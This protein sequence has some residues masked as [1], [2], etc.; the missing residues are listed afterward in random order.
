M[1]RSLVVI[2]RVKSDGEHCQDDYYFKNIAIRGL[3][4]CLSRYR[5]LPHKPDD[6][7]PVP[8][9]MMSLNKNAITRPMAPYNKCSS[10]VYKLKTCLLQGMVMWKIFVADVIDEES[11]QRHLEESRAE[12]ESSRLSP[13][14][15]GSGH[16]SS[17]RECREREK[18]QSMWAHE[19]K[20]G[21]ERAHSW[22]S[23]GI[24]GLES[25][26]REAQKAEK[27]RVG[28]GIRRTANSQ[29]GSVTGTCDTEGGWRP[30]R[31]LVCSY[32]HH[33]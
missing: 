24:R 8:E 31:A 11:S 21:G 10:A 14:S 6:A 29:H 18:R 22:N 13:G 5:H 15:S 12:R 32:R 23:R 3:E 7:R 28:D 1:I 20:R 4:R 33:K 30:A 26:A 16:E 25:G 2:G 19:T 17:G 9:P 27:L